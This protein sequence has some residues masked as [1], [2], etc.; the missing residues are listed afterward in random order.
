MD[1]GLD[2]L[3]GKILS[4]EVLMLEQEERF[5]TKVDANYINEK[6]GEPERCWKWLG[7]VHSSGYGSFNLCYGFD[8]N[9]KR[10]RKNVRAHRLAY[11]LKKGYIPDDLFVLHSCNKKLCVNPDHLRIGT[12]Q[13]NM[14]DYSNFIKEK[15]RKENFNLELV[16]LAKSIYKY[17]EV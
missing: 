12:N 7:S 9:G 6:F 5:W 11:V 1:V 8:E 10:L 15:K 13:D 16:R 3:T 14:N 2:I 4:D 17:R